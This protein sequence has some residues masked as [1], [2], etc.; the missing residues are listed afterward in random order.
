MYLFD[1]DILSNLLSKRPSPRLLTRLTEVPAEQQFT[2][3]IT[4]GEIYYGV[5]RSARA[6]D[7]L[8]RL[9]ETVWP[10][11]QI[12][13]F[14]R[15]AAEAYGKLRAT[16]ERLGRPLPDPDLMIAA[17]ALVRRLT[18]VTG[19]VRHFVRVPELQVENWL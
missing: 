5:C 10:R 19:N 13:P 7:F 17:I 3:T 6:A 15:P 8:P 12:L 16:L 11:V 18:L 14:D 4:V 2:S 9:E 1:T